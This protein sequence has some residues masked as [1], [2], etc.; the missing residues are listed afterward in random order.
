LCLK[1]TIL[2]TNWTHTRT[3]YIS[4]P[5]LADA[6]GY[7]LEYARGGK[8]ARGD[9]ATAD[10]TLAHD[11][12]TAARAAAAAELEAAA[13]GHYPDTSAQFAAAAPVAA[14]PV[15]GSVVPPPGDAGALDVIAGYGSDSSDE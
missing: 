10:G 13:V 11:D 4:R 3:L 1:L 8:R 9:G 14:A 5:A 6:K 7:N 12:G 2:D 15:L